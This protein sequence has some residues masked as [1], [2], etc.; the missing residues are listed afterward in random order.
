MKKPDWLNI[1]ATQ[2]SPPVLMLGRIDAHKKVEAHK[3]KTTSNTQE[4]LN[5][6]V[7]EFLES[8]VDN[9]FLPYSDTGIV[10][11]DQ[12]FIG[13]LGQ[14]VRSMPALEDEVAEDTGL[15][16]QYIDNARHTNDSITLEEFKGKAFTFYMVVAK[17]A[18]GEDVAYAR[19][20]RGFKLTN[21]RWRFMAVGNSDALDMLDKPIF[22][23]DLAFDFALKGSDLAVWNVDS[24]LGLF[25]DEEAL[26]AAV[27]SYLASIR[28]EMPVALS[29]A[30][31]D[32]IAAAASKSIRVA[33]QVRRISQL[34]YLSAVTAPSIQEYLSEVV[35]ISTGIRVTGIEVDVEEQ[36]IQ[37]FLKLVEQRFWRGRFDDSVHEAQAFISPEVQ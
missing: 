5:E 30:T 34:S 13:N 16:V 12:T 9:E 19:R 10:G 28:G 8:R 21:N 18:A 20:I 36:A 32:R 26:Q 17:N 15:L 24:F 3:A 37:P 33:K 27:P 14:I 22:K 31:A 11:A 25:I 7:A 1:D 4:A 23:L 35:E 6:I 2:P 29:D